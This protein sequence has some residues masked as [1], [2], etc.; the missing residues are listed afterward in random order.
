[1]MLNGLLTTDWLDSKLLIGNPAGVTPSRALSIYLPDKNA[2]D[3]GIRYPVLYLLAPWT[4]AGRTSLGWRPFKESFP[5]RVER[6]IGEKKIPPVVV[7]APDLY[8]DYGGSQFIDSSFFGPHA[9]HLVQEVFTYIES[10][11]PVLKGA[12]HRAVIGRSSGGFGALRLAIDFPGSVGA[13]AAHSADLGF[14]N[15]FGTDLL[16]L[17]DKLRR[18]N[19]RVE[20]YLAYV[21]RAAKLNSSDVHT[22]MLLGC[23]GFYSPNPSSPMGY[24]LPLDLYTGEKIP[25]LWQA[26]LGHDPVVRAEKS[27]AGLQA[28]KALYVECGLRDQYRLLYGARRLHLA[29][30]KTG[31]RHR[32]E[33]FDD[34]HSSTDYRYDVSLPEL[35][36]AVV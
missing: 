2:L 5:A 12:R 17:A 25:Y 15:L 21:R 31:T 33:E 9:S 36:A 18:F 11:Y 28:L 27:P 26:W 19:N 14:D 10:K 22:L 32:Y 20:D 6:L 35:I 23:A 4:D 24:E 3:G 29:L 7:V 13:V 34:D 30:E 1:M 8:T 16:T